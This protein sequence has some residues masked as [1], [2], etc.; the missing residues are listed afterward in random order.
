MDEKSILSDLITTTLTKLKITR[1][2]IGE[3][4]L[5]L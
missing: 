1:L 3:R 2:K 4:K 5:K